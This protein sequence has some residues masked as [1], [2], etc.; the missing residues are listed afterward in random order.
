M[1]T[2]NKTKRQNDLAARP[3]AASKPGSRNKSAAL[4]VRNAVCRATITPE[5]ERAMRAFVHRQAA[6]FGLDPNRLWRDCG[7]NVIERG[8][9]WFVSMRE[10]QQQLA[11]DFRASCSPG[12]NS[13]PAI[14][15]PHVETAPAPPPKF[16]SYEDWITRTTYGERAKKFNAAAKKANKKR[17]LSPAPT[18]RLRGKDVAAVCDAARG[19]CVHC[20]SLAVEPRPS[21]P[22]GTPAPWAQV[23]RRIGSLEHHEWR[24]RGGGND[25]PNLA[26]SC[27][28]CN[29]WP[30]ERRRGAVDHGGF[31]PDGILRRLI[32]HR[33][34]CPWPTSPPA[35]CP[36]RPFSCLPASAEP[37]RG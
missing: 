2:S 36:D 14:Q 29:T 18:I 20:G 30:E 19:R 24:V 27:L 17:L 37:S 28:W 8:W 13:T 5:Q 11:A 4:Q 22:S 31:Y 6:N 25:S 21:K 35:G 33:L 23:G 16:R 15:W 32:P 3:S 34:T 12:R 10:R 1:T 26:W 7:Q 9:D